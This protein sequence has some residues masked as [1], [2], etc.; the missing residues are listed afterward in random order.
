MI[1]YLYTRALALTLACFLIVII[2]VLTGVEPLTA[3]ITYLLFWTVSM[4]GRI[5]QIWLSTRKK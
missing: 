5:L 4:D 3:V 1:E 2:V